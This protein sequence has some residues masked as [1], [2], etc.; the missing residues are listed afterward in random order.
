[1]DSNYSNNNFNFSNLG[2]YFENQS[3]CAVDGQTNS[4][5]AP[6]FHAANEK[7]YEC[8]EEKSDDEL[9]IVDNENDST[10]MS[11]DCHHNEVVNDQPEPDQPQT[12]D[13]GAGPN[14]RP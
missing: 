9:I 12:M 5:S 6:P 10:E 11:T 2:S 8:I 3:E 4:S 7:R 1:M 14:E 13:V